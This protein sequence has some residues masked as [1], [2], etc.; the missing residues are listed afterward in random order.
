MIGF[1]EN[2]LSRKTLQRL[3]A[4]AMVF[5]IVALATDATAHFHQNSA[6][7][8]KCQVCQIGHSAAP[9]PSAP[10]AI[11]VPVPVAR[12]AEAKEVTRD[13]T[14]YRAPSIPRAPPA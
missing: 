8:A 7:E 1:P 12:F 13:F 4:V 9:G 11:P 6:D 2:W 3:L 5:S 10:I 14:L